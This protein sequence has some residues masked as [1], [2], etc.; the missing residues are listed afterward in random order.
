MTGVSSTCIVHLLFHF[1]P[2]LL[3]TF[4]V[5]NGVVGMGRLWSLFTLVTL[6][7]SGRLPWLHLYQLIYLRGGIF[8]IPEGENSSDRIVNPNTAQQ[9]YRPLSYH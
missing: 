3:S 9:R 2:F 8:A 7:G 4:A 6:G 5:A 1:F